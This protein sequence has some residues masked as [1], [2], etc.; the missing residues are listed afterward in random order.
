MVAHVSNFKSQ[1]DPWTKNFAQPWY[2]PRTIWNIEVI[3]LNVLWGMICIEF[4][5]FVL[6]F[7]D[8]DNVFFSEKLQENCYLKKVR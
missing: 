1:C 8:I 4:N 7:Q 3:S 5:K 2:K 6:N